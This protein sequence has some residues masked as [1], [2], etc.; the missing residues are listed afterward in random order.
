[1]PNLFAQFAEMAL[2]RLLLRLR[3]DAEEMGNRLGSAVKK[4]AAG[5]MTRE[6]I[7]DWLARDW[8]EGGPIFGGLR[9]AVV[10][11]V[12]GGVSMLQQAGFRE[13]FP[14]AVD[15]T[16]ISIEDDR[17]CDDCAGR[18]GQT[19][20]WAEWEAAGLP[21]VGA[22][23][24]GYRCRCELVPKEEV[25]KDPDLLQPIVVKTVAEYREEYA[26]RQRGD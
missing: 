15:W 14:D 21:G 16:W 8:T 2:Q 25:G 11:S 4:L 20:T 13:Q 9:N 18:H 3:V 22:T 19:K 24:C 5:S 17:R 12:S 1:M 26:R 10:N 23:R 7:E 6:G